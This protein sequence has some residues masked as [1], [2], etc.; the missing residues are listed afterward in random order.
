MALCEMHSKAV[1]C[2]RDEL[3]PRAQRA[4]G[5]RACRWLR[6]SLSMHQPGTSEVGCASCSPP[7]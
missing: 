5:S 1:I 2:Q 4:G 3:G 7:V 6:S